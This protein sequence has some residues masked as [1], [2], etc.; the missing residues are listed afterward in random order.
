VVD[1]TTLK[2]AI[3][4]VK[5]VKHFGFETEN[6][7]QEFI[8]HDNIL[9]F[10]PSNDPNNFT[11]IPYNISRQEVV[12]VASIETVS[13]KLIMTHLTILRLNISISNVFHED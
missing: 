10:I 6:S 7:I 3:G 13:A 2:S 12:L 9:I 1:E 8:Y 11:I 4:K 5:K